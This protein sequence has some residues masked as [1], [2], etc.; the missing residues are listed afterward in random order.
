MVQGASFAGRIKCSNNCFRCP[1]NF[2]FDASIF[3][4]RMKNSEISLEMILYGMFHEWIM[5]LLNTMQVSE[6]F[7]KPLPLPL[8][9]FLN[10]LFVIVEKFHCTVEIFNSSIFTDMEKWHIHFLPLNLITENVR[11]INDGVGKSRWDTVCERE[12]YVI[13]VLV[14][15]TLSFVIF[16]RHH[17][18]C[19]DSFFAQNA[20]N[21]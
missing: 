5:K 3:F 10:S 19:R 20:F 18:T 21:S 13:I 11:W 2:L 4:L 6:N 16:R 12:L 17:A 8:K 15:F 1:F 7:R 9:S 14:G